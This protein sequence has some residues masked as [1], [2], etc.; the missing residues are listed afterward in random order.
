MAPKQRRF[1]FRLI[2]FGFVVIIVSGL[3]LWFL[4]QNPE[5]FGES[6]AKLGTV[7][8][9]ILIGGIFYTA[10]TIKVKLRQHNLIRW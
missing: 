5:T 1:K 8:G 3:F 2:G 7:T 10:Y 4:V 6:T 9:L